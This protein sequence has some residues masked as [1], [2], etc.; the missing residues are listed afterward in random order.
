MASFQTRSSSVSMTRHCFREFAAQSQTARLWRL[1][2]EIRSVRLFLG[3]LSS[4]FWALWMGRLTAR[5]ANV[6][7]T[8]TYR[9]THSACRRAVDW[10][11]LRARGSLRPLAQPRPFRTSPSATRTCRAGAMHEACCR[12]H[13]GSRGR[14]LQGRRPE[15]SP[16]S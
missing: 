14:L 13:C 7:V 11:S 16:Q 2:I 9:P 3:G 12:I 10:K 4:P 5:D 1:S 6:F 15:D 8:Y